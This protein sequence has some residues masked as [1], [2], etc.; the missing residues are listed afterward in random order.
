MRNYCDV[1]SAAIEPVTELKVWNAEK[2]K[3]YRFCSFECL[4]KM[5]KKSKKR[6]R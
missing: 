1:C 4:K 3:I 6:R 2:K 5:Q